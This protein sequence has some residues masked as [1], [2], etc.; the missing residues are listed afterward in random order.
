ML[1]QKITL[2]FIDT[3]IC[4]S[5]LEAQRIVSPSNHSLLKRF[6]LEEEI[7]SENDLEDIEEF[8]KNYFQGI[9][10]NKATRRDLENLQFLNNKQVEN[11]LAY[12]YQ[13][14][15]Q[16]VYELQLID[17]L[18]YYTINKLTQVIIV[19]NVDKYKKKETLHSL[20]KQ[21]KQELSSRLDYPLYKRKGYNNKFLG[22]PWYS[23]IR[24]SFRVGHIVEWG[25]N[26]E[27]DEGEPFFALKNKKGYDYLSFHLML[28]NWRWIKDL[29]V[30]N[31]K[32]NFGEGLTIGSNGFLHHYLPAFIYPSLAH[33]VKKHHSNDEYNYLSGIAATFQ[34]H[35][36][37]EFTP[38]YSLRKLD[39]KIVNNC[40]KTIYKNGKHRTNKDFIYRNKAYQRLVGLNLNFILS[41][42]RFGLTA[43]SIVYNYPLSKK[44]SLYNRYYPQ[45]KSFYNL[46]LHYQYFWMNFR[47]RGEVVKGK[48]GIASINYLLYHAKPNLDFLLLHRYYSSD[49]WGLLSKSYGVSHRIQNENGWAFLCQYVP[50]YHYSFNLSLD[51][52]SFP[53]CSY[54]ISKPSK[55]CV[56]KF[57]FNGSCKSMGYSLKYTFKHKERDVAYT[58]GKIIVP[59]QQHKISLIGTYKFLHCLL[60]THAS[61]VYFNQQKVKNSIGYQL[62]QSCKIVYNPVSIHWQASFFHSLDADSKLYIYEPNV[63]YSYGFHSFIGRGYR[64]SLLVRCDVTHSLMLMAKWG[65][66]HYFDRETI[67]VGID[68]IN[69]RN[70]MDLQFFLRVKF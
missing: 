70:K 23:N 24:Y 58:K 20:F 60:K 42:I 66:T 48:K 29:V 43:I 5:L 65:S 56:G 2:L 13:H 26:A 8:K 18:D 55:G 63:L 7:T 50:S 45:G 12:V 36:S 30:G 16:S 61:Y 17:N 51:F 44:N 41:R 57:S 37:I 34:C 15:L 47:L 22:L 40:I 38:F 62:T 19:N 3:F 14:P 28:H 53:W 39:A 67:G 49:Y 59:L 69:N 35:K 1:I 54:R 9:D 21:T 33:E 68:E 31:Y 25:L 32:L 46:G 11:I 27:K 52:Y 4:C 10:I 64:L 6:D